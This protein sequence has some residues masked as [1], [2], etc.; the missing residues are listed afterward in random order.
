MELPSQSVNYQDESGETKIVY[1]PPI[2]CGKF[3][4]WKPKAMYRVQDLALVPHNDVIKQ[5]D[6]LNIMIKKY[7]LGP[8]YDSF[9]DFDRAQQAEI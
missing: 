2:I 9:I 3:T 1:E 5:P 8:G 7:D 4:N 6:Y